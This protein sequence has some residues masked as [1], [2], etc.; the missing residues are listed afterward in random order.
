MDSPTDPTDKT[1]SGG[2]GSPSIPAPVPT[3]SPGD[4]F[5]S[6]VNQRWIRQTSIPTFAGSFGV[7]EEIEERVRGA[8]MRSIRTQMRT[9]PDAPLSQ[10]AQSVLHTASQPN[11]VRDLRHLLQSFACMRTPEDVATQIGVLNR[12]QVRAPLTFSIAADTYTSRICRV[13]VYEPVLGLPAKHYYT[14]GS[15]NRIILRYAALLKEAGTLL[16]VPDLDSVL[17]IERSVLPYLSEGDS[18]RNPDESYVPM[19]LSQLRRTYKHIPWEPMFAAWG[20]KLADIRD[21]TFILT[22]DRYVKALNHMFETFE[23]PMWRIWLRAGV[24]LS[25]IEYL[26]P[27]FDDLHYELFGRRLRGNSQ[28]LPQKF[29]MLRVLQTFVTQ[30]FSKL[31]VTQ[32]VKPEIKE[33]VTRMIERLKGATLNRIGHITWMS[34]PTKRTALKKVEAMRFE[35]AYPRVWANEFAGTTIDRE[36]M[37][38]NILNLSIRDTDRMIGNLGTGCGKSDGTW[39]DGAFDVNAYYYPDKNQLTIPAGMLRPPFFD[40]RRSVAWNYGGIGCAI[41][42]EITHGFDADGK[43]YDLR[44]SYKDWW[45]EKDNTAYTNITTGLIQLYD[46]QEY[47]GG[48]VDGSLTLSENIADLGGVAIALDALNTYLKSKKVSEKEMLDAYRDFFTSYAVSWRNK[49]RPRKAKQSLYLDV[50]APAPLRVN[51]VV[52]QFDEFYRAFA[53]VKDDPGW[54]DP[55]ER[56]V[57]W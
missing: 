2:Q 17:S 4:D 47:A 54:I 34:P 8:L 19:R 39:E 48:R 40:M 52:R 27:P 31:F 50:H 26:P 13:H 21:T 45:T 37:L 57:V 42:H 12:L 6:H 53:I 14:S 38:C 23:M 49:D 55:K 10:L 25:V 56:I 33:E 7:S 1:Q 51:L 28:K 32:Y 22:N 30:Q 9:E 24:L 41:G 18:L 36:R 16:E 11:N 29:L 15:K 20:L 5:Y 43:N 35:V 44:G 3:I 46:G